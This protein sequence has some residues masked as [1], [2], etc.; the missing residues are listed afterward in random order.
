MLVLT[1]IQIV[2]TLT[3]KD[4]CE[5]VNFAKKLVDNNKSMKNYPAC[6]ELNTANREHK[7][8]NTHSR[9]HERI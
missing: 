7:L 6:K 1:L 5:K 2:D 4:F 9:R 8:T 3:L